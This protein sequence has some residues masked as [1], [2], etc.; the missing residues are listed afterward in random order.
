MPDGYCLGKITEVNGS[1]A[2]FT[3]AY[4]SRVTLCVDEILQ[5]LNWRYR[6]SDLLG[7]P[8]I[9]IK[10]VGG[11]RGAFTVSAVKLR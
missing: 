9:E 6:A 11:T 7:F 1:L 10:L 4:G 3:T 2:I 5:K 8:N